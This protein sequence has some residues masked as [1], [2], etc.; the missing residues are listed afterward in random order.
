MIVPALLLRKL[1]PFRIERELGGGGMG[2]VYLAHDEDEDRSVALTVMRPDLVERRGFFK[3]FER[4]ARAGARVEHA[5]VVRTLESGFQIVGGQTLCYVVMEYVEGRTLREILR[6]LGTVPEAL[7]REIAR[8]VAS[9]LVAIHA[10]GIVHRDLKPEN[11][12]ITTDH[13]VRIMD[14][15]VAKALDATQALTQEGQFAGT[16]VYAAPEQFRGGAVE[17]ATD[18]YALGVVLH[19]LATGTNPFARNTPAEVLRAHLD[20]TAPDLEDVLPDLSPFLAEL[21]AQLLE[22]NADDRFE[23]AAALSAVLDEGEKSAWW[24]QRGEERRRRRSGIPRVPVRRETALHGR[25]GDLA[26]LADLWTKAKSGQGSTL[27]VEGEAGIGKSRLI[28]AFLETLAKEPAHVLYGSYA[29]AGGLG[30]LA[31]AVLQRFGAARLDEALRPY[32][33]VTPGLVPAF[34][35]L[36]RSEAPPEG[37]PSLQGDVLHA[38]FVHLMRG[39][40]AE[41]PL[42][43]VVEDLHFATAETRRILLSLARAVEGH[44]VLLVLTSRPPVPEDEAALFARTGVFRRTQLARLG[45]RDVIQLLR[46]AFKNERLVEKLAPKIAEKSDGVPFFIFEMIR[47]LKEGQ[48]IT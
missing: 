33:T 17:S 14:L 29:P 35:A 13:R 43:W 2:R 44:R 20:E 16:F 40:A 18:L 41:R 19:E 3:R 34:A 23:S 7:V 25:E 26:L 47:G 27:L 1:G 9:G 39:L 21:V 11:V 4:E 30:G 37:A 24:A 45:V 15:G 12:L 6:E 28:D 36:L 22:K 10:A 42:V 38:V 32:L 48:F 8:Q 31:D 5:N 46:D